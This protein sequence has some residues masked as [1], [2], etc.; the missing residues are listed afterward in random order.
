M[1]SYSQ[2]ISSPPQISASFPPSIHVLDAHRCCQQQ[3]QQRANA[4]DEEHLVK[5]FRS[6]PLLPQEATS[7]SF[8]LTAPQ[9]TPHW[10]CRTEDIVHHPT[11]AAPALSLTDSQPFVL[12]PCMRQFISATAPLPPHD[13]SPRTTIATTQLWM[14]ET[15]PSL[16]IFESSSSSFDSLNRSIIVD[17]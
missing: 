5:T 8:L 1:D 4:N 7:F 10:L 6:P 2:T 11:A 13:V 17:E 12:R 16:P 14:I 15:P 9:V 3:H